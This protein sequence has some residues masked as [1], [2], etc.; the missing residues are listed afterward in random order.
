MTSGRRRSKRAWLGL[1][2]AV[3]LYLGLTVPTIDRQGVNWDEHDDRSIAL[4]YLTPGGLWAGST[5][6]LNQTRLPMYLGA[7]A[8]Q[9][10]GHNSIRVARLLSCAIG[11][12]TILGVW[13]FC[14][15]EW[16][17]G[18]AVVGSLT[19][20]TSP[21]FIA[22]SRLAFSEGD[23]YITCATVWVAVAAGWFAR[24]A[25][26]GRAAVLG[27]AL[28]V[29]IAAKLS[30][31]ALIPA[32]GI[33]VLLGRSERREPSPTLRQS[34]P[35]WVL[36]AGLAI[37]VATG[38]ELGARGIARPGNPVVMVGLAGTALLWV[39]LAAWSVVH[40]RA[41][42]GRVLRV[43]IPAAVGICTFLLLPPVHTTNPRIQATIVQELVEGGGSFD[44]LRAAESGA[45]HGMTVLIKP[46]I[47]L[48]AA[49]WLSL[50][51]ALA[52]VG[53]DRGARL[54]VLIVMFYV[55]FLLTLPW[56]QTRYMM[57]VAAV[58]TMLLA[59]TVVRAW[60]ARRT[61]VGVVAA[62]A[63]VGL[64]A[65]FVVY[66]PDLHLNGY[67][68]LGER[69]LFGR[70]TIGYRSVVH[71]PIDG[72]EQTLAWVG[73]HAG[74]GDR[75]LTMSPPRHIVRSLTRGRGYEWIDGQVER[76]AIGR[77]DWVLTDLNGDIRPGEGRDNPT[78]EVRAY[79]YDRA[80]LERDFERVFAVER[81][82]GLEVATVWR[83]KHPAR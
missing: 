22:F 18:A 52:R 61:L 81:A 3:A 56:A 42:A 28:G 31:I 48:G 26:V 36:A 8:F 57:P 14:R 34:W 20:A 13:V 69:Y 10:T 16:G 77:A 64:V 55:A 49:L 66:Y 70:S 29:A 19:L 50:A 27:L 67:R 5:V 51:L 2:V 47:V 65:D 33:F 24:S 63:L 62:V 12:L 21:Y 53:V 39:G 43:A 25:T 59:A 30:A 4:T 11:V 68:L 80:E 38:L 7:M 44:I 6:D 79:P 58:L 45:L 40:R 75:V 32:V 23:I 35:F 76:D 1:A 71:V 46:S 74:P 83:R 73:R 41:A 37:G 72:I 17:D 54:C 9:A 15:R 60:R 82:C 78:G